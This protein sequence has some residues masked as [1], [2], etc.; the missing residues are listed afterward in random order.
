M[1][2]QESEGFASISQPGNGSIAGNLRDSIEE[3][4]IAAEVPEVIAEA[5]AAAGLEEIKN[6]ASAEVIG[7][8]D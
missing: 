5:S 1:S 4:K 7:N 2:I 6:D 3:V 8:P